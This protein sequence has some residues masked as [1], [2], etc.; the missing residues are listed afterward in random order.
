M[1][2]RQISVFLENKPGKLSEMTALLAKEKIDIRALSLAETKDFG[3]ARMITSNA[4]ETVRILRQGNYLADFS[5]VLAYAVP[6]TPGGLDR[7]LAAFNEAKVNIEYMYAFLSGKKSD[8]AY[9]I[10]RVAGTE[11][12]ET[13]LRDLGL[14]SLT[15]QEIQGL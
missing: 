15:Q 6:D 9:M 10:F 13:A 12:A 7:L 4:D 1:S 5:P 11:K 2:I 8:Q 14:N 3:I